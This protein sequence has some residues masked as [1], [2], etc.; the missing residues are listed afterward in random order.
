MKVL[1]KVDFFV[2]LSDKEAR[3][4]YHRLARK[5]HPDR[6]GGSHARFIE[7]QRQWDLFRD[8]KPTISIENIVIVNYGPFGVR[9]SGS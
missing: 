7:L 6:E 9:E 5:F 3:K 2:G 4:T 1:S 8:P